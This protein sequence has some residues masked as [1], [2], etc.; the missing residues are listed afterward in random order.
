MLNKIDNISAGSEYSKSARPSGFGINAASAYN[1]R[2]DIHD[3]VNISPALQFLNQV[4]WRLKEFKHSANE[5]LF[6]DF[7]VSS[8]E[9]RTTI[10]L[11]NINLLGSL[12]YNLIKEGSPAVSTSK[13]YS[14]LSSAIGEINYDTVP[15]LINFSALNVF[16]GRV[17]D[18]HIYRELTRSDSYIFEELLNGIGNGIRNEFDQLNSQVFI[19]LDKLINIKK[20]SRSSGEADFDKVIT[21]K[22]VKVINA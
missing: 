17:F 13:I 4:N 7:I 16:F 15:V 8:I 14:D 18:M 10:D 5:K 2:A 20:E 12:D 9:F 6:L 22:S 1:R 19:F 11:V 3:S 21:I